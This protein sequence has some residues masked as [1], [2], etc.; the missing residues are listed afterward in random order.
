MSG[1]RAETYD[2]II[3]GGGPAGSICARYRDLLWKAFG[4]PVTGWKFRAMEALPPQWFQIT[5]RALLSIPR[6]ARNIV[7]DRFF[8]QEGE[9]HHTS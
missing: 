8:L 1:G 2:A 4:K 7:L 5:G 6:L 3:V 9:A